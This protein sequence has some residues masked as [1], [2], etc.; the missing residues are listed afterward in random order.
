[1]SFFQL[2]E[3][4][5]CI[6]MHSEKCYLQTLKGTTWSSDKKLNSAIRYI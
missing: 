2:A 5:L 4:W 1:M 3:D 6:F